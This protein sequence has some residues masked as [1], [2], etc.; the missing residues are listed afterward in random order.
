M[1]L[2]V[3]IFLVLINIHNTIQTNSP[4]VCHHHHP[5]YQYII[6]VIIITTITLCVGRGPHSHRVLG[7][8]MH[9]LCLRRPPWVHRYSSQA[10]AEKG[11]TCLF[12]HS[13]TKDE[14]MTTVHLWGHFL[15]KEYIWKPPL[16]FFIMPTIAVCIYHYQIAN[17][18]FISLFVFWNS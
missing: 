5:P 16:P 15:S 9:H 14:F 8:C 11:I 18:I 17:F 12:L 4:K 3:T 13:D 2:L 10:Q 6:I 7:D 1:T